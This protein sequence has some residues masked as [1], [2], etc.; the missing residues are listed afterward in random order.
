MARIQNGP[1]SSRFRID[2]VTKSIQVILGGGLLYTNF[3]AMACWAKLGGAK[4]GGQA[5]FLD[6]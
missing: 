6:V 3:G 5:G 2:G 4:L 1:V